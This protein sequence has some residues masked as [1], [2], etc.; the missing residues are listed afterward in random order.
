[1]GLP[2]VAPRT[3]QPLPGRFGAFC[4]PIHRL[5]RTPSAGGESRR[6][7]AARRIEAVRGWSR[8]LALKRSSQHADDVKTTLD[9]DE[10]LY[11]AV[12]M[13]AARIGRTVHEIIEEALETWLARAEEEEHRQSAAVALEERDRSVSSESWYTTLDGGPKSTNAPDEG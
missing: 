8:D 11:S 5:C 6:Q 9:L 10:D 3:N 7:L 12:K 4:R 13:Q 1:M 2:R